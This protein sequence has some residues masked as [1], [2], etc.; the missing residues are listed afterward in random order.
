MG[1][2]SRPGQS[3]DHVASESSR[4]VA[5]VPTPQPHA[6]PGSGRPTPSTASMTTPA[7]DSEVDSPTGRG[8]Q[9]VAR[10]GIVS[11]SLAGGK[12]TPHLHDGD[13]VRDMDNMPQG[14]SMPVMSRCQEQK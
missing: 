2:Q 11:R 10:S 6:A 13:E 5:E 9:R 12:W 4:S 1:G 14:Y 7:G 8:V 3:G